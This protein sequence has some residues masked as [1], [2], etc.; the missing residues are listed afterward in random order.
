MLM[1]VALGGR[2]KLKGAIIGT[3]LVNCLYSV[4]TSLFPE[5]WLFILGLLY[6]LTVL[7][8][9]KG[10]LGLF[11]TIGNKISTTLKRKP[12]ALDPTS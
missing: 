2:G 1:W 6:V 5:G 7:Y 8:F 3:L 10:F 12:A 11:E 9:Q 4:C